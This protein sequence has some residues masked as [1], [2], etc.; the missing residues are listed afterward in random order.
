MAGLEDVAWD[1]RGL[2]PVVVQDGGSGQVLMLAYAN[3]EAVEMTLESGLAHFWSRSRKRL[4]RKGETSGHLLPIVEVR[5]DC[6]GDALL[7]RV[8]AS[9]PACHTGEASCFYRTL[10]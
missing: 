10:A 4:W 1:E 8:R 7:Y 2:V 9:G 6:D 3:R 5:V